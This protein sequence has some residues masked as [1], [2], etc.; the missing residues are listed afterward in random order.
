[1]FE[2]KALQDL[3][4]KVTAPLFA[5]CPGRCPARL[6]TALHRARTTASTRV[7]NSGRLANRSRNGI[8][9][10]TTH[11]RIGTGGNTSS[12]SVAA[13]SA[14]PPEA[15]EAGPAALKAGEAEAESAI[16]ITKTRPAPTPRPSERLVNLTDDDPYRLVTSFAT[17]SRGALKV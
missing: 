5:P 9:N 6:I 15:H 16:P 13:V 7:S 12:T 3:W 17:S 10:V 11:W 4:M 1:M 2:F 8:G 14:I